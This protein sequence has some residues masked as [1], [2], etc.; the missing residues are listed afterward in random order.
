[1]GKIEIYV[2]WAVSNIFYVHP[3]REKWSN[4]TNYVSN[5][6]K[7]PPSNYIYILIYN[8]YDEGW[9][10]SEIPN[11]YV[12]LQMC[13]P[14]EP[15]MQNGFNLIK[16]K[17]LPPSTFQ[18]ST[19]QPSNLHDLFRGE[20]HRSSI[21]AKDESRLSLSWQLRGT[22]IRESHTQVHPL[23]VWYIYLHSPTK[24]AKWCQM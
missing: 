16:C 2:I 21:T 7:P 15:Q 20:D 1:M 5:G 24:M 3:Y 10:G 12:W 17:T 22:G 14:L 6:L 9:W 11:D 8:L 4:L 23:D 18:P 19:F 13:H